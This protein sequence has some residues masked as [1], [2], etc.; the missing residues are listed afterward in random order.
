MAGVATKHTDY[1][2]LEDRWER[3]RDAASGSDAVK[4]SGLK[5]LPALDSHQRDVSKY[6]EYRMRAL[7]Y[8]A[9]GR[10]I[11]G[12]SGAIFQKAPSVD[13]ISAKVTEHAQDITLT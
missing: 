5:Y 9:T 3:C 2:D 8:N 1:E 7:F 4:E 12:L 6:D 11:A 13:D 10:T